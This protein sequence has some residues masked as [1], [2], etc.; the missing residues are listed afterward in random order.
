MIKFAQRYLRSFLITGY[1]VLVAFPLVVSAA[2]LPLE[3]MDNDPAATG[4]RLYQR[5]AGQ[6]YDYSDWIYSGFKPSFD[7]PDLDGGVT[8]FFVVRAFNSN[9]E[10]VDSN[11][12]EFTPTDDPIDDPPPAQDG[13]G[14]GVGDP[15]DNCLSEPNPLQ[16][17]AD[18]DGWGDACDNCPVPNPDQADS[19][20]DGEA[21]ACDNCP[22]VPN[23]GQEDLDGDGEGDACD[24][25][26]DGDAAPNGAD[27]APLDPGDPEPTPEVTSA[28]SSSTR[29]CCGKPR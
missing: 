1:Y 16:A 5:T 20:G 12:I 26:I 3:W 24:G 18:G 28:N 10:S 23:A 7:V 14:D 8:Y 25:D 9:E 19:D 27:C 29:R 21:D 6:V 11:E 17:D 15:C 2:S 4:Y 22:L 13:D